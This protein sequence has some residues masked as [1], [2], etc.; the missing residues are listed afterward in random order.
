MIN[1]AAKTERGP[2]LNRSLSRQSITLTC[3]VIF[4]SSRGRFCLLSIVQD[5]D[6]YSKATC[7]WLSTTWSAT[8]HAANTQEANRQ[9]T[10]QINRRTTTRRIKIILSASRSGSSCRRND[11]AQAIRPHRCSKSTSQS[12][13][14]PPFDVELTLVSKEN[15]VIIEHNNR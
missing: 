12:K 7:R 9:D 3:I 8:S 11:P 15:P 5:K 6:E 2:H 14:I 4:C 13:T 1:L 10:A